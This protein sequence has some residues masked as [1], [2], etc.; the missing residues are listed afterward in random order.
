VGHDLVLHFPAGYA[1]ARLTGAVL[2]KLLGIEV[3]VRN[4]RTV[5][6]LDRLL[7]TRPGGS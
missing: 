4:W 2:E 5:E 6:K 7:V 3:T 1:A